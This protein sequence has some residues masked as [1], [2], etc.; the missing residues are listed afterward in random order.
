MNM[1]V[2]QTGF[3]LAQGLRVYAIGDIHGF[4]DALDRMHD[5]IAADLLDHPPESAHIVYLG[6]YIDRG[7][8]SK[9][10]IDR[11]IARR[12]RGDG[13]EKTFILGNHEMGLYE[14]TKNPHES[15]WLM[16]GG[17][18]TLKS[19]G[20]VFAADV[21]LPG[22]I[23]DAAGRLLNVLP[24]AH[25]EFLEA[26]EYYR[27]IGDYFFVHAGI[28]PLKPLEKNTVRDFT[29]IRE[30]FLSW[31]AA[32][33]KMIVHGHTISEKPEI[34]K[35]RIGVDTGLYAG[36]KLTAAVLENDTVRFLQ[37]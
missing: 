18:E 29:F 37:V 28:D 13:I 25:R 12:D 24:P 16:Y 15:R 11:L 20:I 36:G 17:I 6:D 3:S 22:E 10:V 9:G 23:E 7:P 31:P 2:T 21:P 14:F 32:F 8:D 19:Y 30:P 26:L 1:Q 4:S 35:H 34:K 33:S 27:A 5:A